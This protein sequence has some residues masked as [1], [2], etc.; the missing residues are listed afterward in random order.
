MVQCAEVTAFDGLMIIPSTHFN[1]C[2]C[3]GHIKRCVRLVPSHTSNE[4]SP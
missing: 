2:T 4:L 1:P 3:K